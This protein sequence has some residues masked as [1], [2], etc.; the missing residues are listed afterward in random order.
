[1]RRVA[2][3][4][5]FLFC[6]TVSFA[7]LSLAR[8]GAVQRHIISPPMEKV[9][10]TYEVSNKLVSSDLQQVKPQVMAQTPEKSSLMP[11]LRWSRVDTAVAYEVD[12]LKKNEDEQ[13]S[14]EPIMPT[15]R[16]YVTGYMFYLPKDFD[17]DVFYWRVRGIDLDGNGVSDYSD[18][19]PVYVN[20]ALPIIEKPVPL[21]YYDQGNGTV[22]LY[23]VYDWI[24]IP[25]ADKYEIEILDAAPENPNGTEPSVHRIDLLTCESSEQYDP[26]SR[27]SDTVLY[28]RVRGMDNLG[29]TIGV[30]S[31]AVPFKT[32]P[33]DNYE[34]ATLGDSISHGGGSISYSPSDWAFSYQYYLD[35]PTINLAQSGDTSNMT[36]ERFERD[37][38]PFHPK[39]LIILMGSNSLRAGESPYSVI[40]D[41]KKVKEACLDHDIKPVFLTVPPINPANIKKAFDQDTAEDWQQRVAIVNAWIRTQVYIDITPGMSD[42]DGDLFTYLA[43]DGLHL[44][45]QGKQMIAGAINAEWKYILSLPDDA[46]EKE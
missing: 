41:M 31:D 22:L 3:I 43:L 4:T 44:D 33:E 26:K 16:V 7:F 6:F 38:L 35:F 12:I 20:R 32:S 27:V 21:S 19:E 11:L 5:M 46:W 28:W 39:Y 15:K 13:D 40:Y 9:R 36:A 14:Y 29:H 18:V 34:V 8:P 42:T 24:P 30:Y 2:Y 37:V 17:G 25:E 45:P 10:K 1:M 23:P